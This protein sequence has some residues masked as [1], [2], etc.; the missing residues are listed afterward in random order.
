MRAC[1]STFHNFISP[2]HP[3]DANRLESVRE[4]A[5]TATVEW[6]PNSMLLSAGCDGGIVVVGSLEVEVEVV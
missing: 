6:W 1:F 5:N 2:D 4:K 3:P